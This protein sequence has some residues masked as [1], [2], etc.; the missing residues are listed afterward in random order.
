[1]PDLHASVGAQIKKRRD[2][3]LN[4]FYLFQNTSDGSGVI[5]PLS[6]SV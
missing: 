6:Q 1:M 2:Q 5:L 3:V 4:W